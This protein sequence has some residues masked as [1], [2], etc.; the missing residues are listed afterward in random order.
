[1]SRDVHD[2]PQMREHQ[3][4]GGFEITL[5]A[6]ALSERA[7]IIAAENWNTAHPLE[8]GVEAPEWA[9]QGQIARAGNQCTCSH[10]ISRGLD[11]HF[12]SRP[13]RV[14][15]APE[16]PLRVPGGP[17]SNNSLRANAAFGIPLLGKPEAT[18]GRVAGNAW[19]QVGS[20][21]IRFP[22]RVRPNRGVP[23]RTTARE[24]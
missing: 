3:L 19:A 7:L 9:G 5:G 1:A 12:S 23:A 18:G 10:E 24:K 2:E 4:P 13:I 11:R 15:N 8:I 20:T 21:E 17:L 16:V 14:L 6:E 22:S